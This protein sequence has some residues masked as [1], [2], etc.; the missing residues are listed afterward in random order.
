M[1][2]KPGQHP[3]PTEES[4]P[5]QGLYGAQPGAKFR[6]N[7]LHKTVS[8][9]FERFSAERGESTKTVRVRVVGV[10]AETGGQNDLN[11]VIPLKTARD[12]HHWREGVTRAQAQSRGYESA[13]V[14][15]KGPE[16]VEEVQQ[17]IERLGFSSFSMKQMLQAV[18]TLS[19]IVQ[20]IL[21]G[22]GGIALLVA[23]FGIMNTMIMSIYERTREIGIL[24][25][26]G[27]SV[28]DIKR[29]FL[30]EA[31]AIGFAGGVLGLL[32]GWTGTQLINFAA[33]A[34]IVRAGGNPVTVAYVPLWLA[35]F[36]V[37]FTTLVGLVAGLY[38]AVRAARLEP[39]TAIRQE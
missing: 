15:V 37:G 10:M 27:S 35:L 28:G 22:I 29:I 39:L 23:S 17:E 11:L 16:M 6:V 21:G 26:I 33:S 4:A 9:G 7:L 25:V 24:K 3:P 1:S 14:K 18:G 13:K 36:A 31:G 2:G 30:F 20:V 19:K 32:V 38:P 8:L 12:L 34:F 5:F